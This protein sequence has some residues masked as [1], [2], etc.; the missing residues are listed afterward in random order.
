MI[1]VSGFNV[2]RIK[3]DKKL[4]TKTYLSNYIVLEL[5]SKEEDVGS[6]STLAQN[7]F[8]NLESE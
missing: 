1:T 5:L 4:L 3:V 7:K 8:T 6:N 2:L